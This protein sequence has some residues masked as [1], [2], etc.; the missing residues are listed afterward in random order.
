MKE[1]YA[2]SDPMEK[3]VVM[4]VKAAEQA[5]AVV[6]LVLEEDLDLAAVSILNRF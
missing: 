4:G 6:D 3:K 5:V 2:K 1:N